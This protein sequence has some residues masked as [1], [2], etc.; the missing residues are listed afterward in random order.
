MAF[1]SPTKSWQ[2]CNAHQKRECKAHAVFTVLKKSQGQLE[3]EIRNAQAKLE[4]KITALRK[5]QQLNKDLDD[6]ELTLL[7]VTQKIDKVDS[8]PEQIEVLENVY[9]KIEP[10]F[11][12]KGVNGLNSDDIKSLLKNKELSKLLKAMGKFQWTGGAIKQPNGK[13]S[14]EVGISD[15]L[16]DRLMSKSEMSSLLSFWLDSGDKNWYAAIKPEIDRRKQQL[17]LEKSRPKPDLVNIKKL[18]QQIEKLEKDW[19]L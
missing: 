8:S 7:A 11:E 16:L 13:S 17:A 2:A 6:K 14:S 1:S 9:D 10:F 5:K 4:E 19:T 12:V 3:A 18:E 15:E